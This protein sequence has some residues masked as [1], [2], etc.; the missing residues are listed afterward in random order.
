MRNDNPRRI[1]FRCRIAAFGEALVIALLAMVKERRV[2]ALACCRLAEQPVDGC[3]SASLFIA[4]ALW[5]RRMALPPRQAKLSWPWSPLAGATWPGWLWAPSSSGSP[6][7]L[8]TRTIAGGG[9]EKLVY[10]AA[11]SPLPSARRL[12][13]I[14]RSECPAALY[15]EPAVTGLSILAR[16][17]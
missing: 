2:R 8:Y 16:R 7:A 12:P 13:G 4:I 15:P 9:G 17:R 14:S 1:L 3:P 6:I 11:E 10:P 5:A